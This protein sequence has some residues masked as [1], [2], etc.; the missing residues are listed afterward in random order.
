MDALVALLFLR[1]RGLRAYLTMSRRG[2][3][4]YA[5]LRTSQAEL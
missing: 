3:G 1:L 5:R 4:D 2:Q